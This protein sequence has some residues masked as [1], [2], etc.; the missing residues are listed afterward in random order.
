MMNN[1][2]VCVP[3]SLKIIISNK[4]LII[5][6]DKVIPRFDWFSVYPACNVLEG[7]MAAVGSCKLV[8]TFRPFIIMFELIR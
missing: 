3:V 4:N 2:N 6:Y 7:K 5:F 8:E 1:N